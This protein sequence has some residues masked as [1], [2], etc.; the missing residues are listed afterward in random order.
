[1][2][3]NLLYY[4][5]LESGK[6]EMRLVGDKLKQLGKQEEDLNVR[7]SDAEQR[8]LELPSPEQYKLSKKEYKNLKQ[9]LDT[10]IT[11]SSAQQKRP[12][13]SKLVKSITVYPDKL[14]AEYHPPIITNKKS[15]TDEGE[16]FLVTSVASPTG[17]E[18]VL[19]A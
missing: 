3:V 18:P 15:P 11:D 8:L 7:L 10:L 14:T 16:G 2:P 9:E 1:L 6:L 17:F 4:E 13:L 12:F 19:P 5:G